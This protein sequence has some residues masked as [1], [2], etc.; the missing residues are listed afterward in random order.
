MV[1]VEAARCLILELVGED[2]GVVVDPG[3]Y[4]ES[5]FAFSSCFDRFPPVSAV[6]T[7]PQDPSSGRLLLKAR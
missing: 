5:L 6:I 7:P 3:E 4:P 2:A 1:V